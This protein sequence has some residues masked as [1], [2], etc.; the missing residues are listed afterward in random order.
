MPWILLVDDD[1]GMVET[2][3]DI[4]RARRYDV[5]TA[6]SGES[7]VERV[8]ESAFDVVLMDIQMPGLNGVEALQAMKAMKPDLKVIMMTAFTRDDLVQEARRA[9]AV[10][11]VS[12]PL[13]LDQVLELVDRVA[14]AA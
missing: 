11:V 4:L 10:A 13:E 14:R 8:R 2:L 6:D 3:S 5:V 9:S 7:A 1:S 12:K